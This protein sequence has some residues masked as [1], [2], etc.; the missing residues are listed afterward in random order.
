MNAS[1]P[2]ERHI[3]TSFIAAVGGGKRT[4]ADLTAEDKQRLDEDLLKARKG[5]YA[6]VARV[7]SFYATPDSI[8]LP[9]APRN[10]PSSGMPLDRM[11][12][13]NWNFWITEDVVRGVA[14]ANTGFENVLTAP[15]KR[16]VQLR[17]EPIV[18]DGG[19]A[20]APA[21]GAAEGAPA[22]AGAPVDP[23]PEIPLNFDASFTGRQTNDLYDVRRVTLR[24]VAATSHLPRIFDALAKQNFIT[25]TNTAMKPADPFAAAREGFLYGA[26]PVSEVTLSLEIIQLRE[27]TTQRMPEE[28]K[29]RLGTQGLIQAT[30]DAT[31]GAGGV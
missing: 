21:P 3:A 27:W 10:V 28:M 22:V 5:V 20:P 17:I 25:I 2:I 13:W 19:P 8:G 23:K 29:A 12:E 24:I 11:F 9:L 15:L 7:I 16:I 26:E 1:F 30:G 6:E 31:G 18:R 4:R 14:A